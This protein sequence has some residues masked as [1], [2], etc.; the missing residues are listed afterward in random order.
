[1]ASLEILDGIS[2]ELAA[3]ETLERPCWPNQPT[4]CNVCGGHQYSSFQSYKRHWCAKHENTFT[5]LFCP[6]CNKKFGRKPDLVAHQRKI[7]H[8]LTTPIQREVPNK[9]YIDPK[10]TPPYMV[11]HRQ[12]LRLQRARDV[13]EASVSLTTER[14]DCRDETF[15]L[16]KDNRV[17]FKKFKS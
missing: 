11:D 5:L 7:H 9:A 12:R 14:A 16:S 10:G 1:M 3:F 13:E 2:Q 15:E 4:A 6:S 8:L 17:V